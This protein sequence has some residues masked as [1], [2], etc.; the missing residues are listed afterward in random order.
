MT[1][2]VMKFPL[3]IE[4]NLGEIIKIDEPHEKGQIIKNLSNYLQIFLPKM[5]WSKVIH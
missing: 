5:Q 3:Y 1:K 2:M 4:K